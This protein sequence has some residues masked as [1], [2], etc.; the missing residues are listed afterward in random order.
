MAMLFERCDDADHGYPLRHSGANGVEDLLGDAFLG[1]QT[2]YEEV[3]A[4]LGVEV[5][6]GL[7]GDKFVPESR[8][9]INIERMSVDVHPICG[10]CQRARVHV[11]AERCV[12]ATEDEIDEG[13]DAHA[14]ASK[15]D[16]NVHSVAL[17]ERNKIR[18][19]T[20]GSVRERTHIIHR[21]GHR[22]GS[23]FKRV[24]PAQ[25]TQHGGFAEELA[26]YEEISR[27]HPREAGVWGT[28]AVVG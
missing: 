13:A 12:L 4:P 23:S 27:R 16:N 11:G 22:L 21:Q 28:H 2:V 8:D 7:F 3:Y 17:L 15:D 6:D 14:S 19:F 25:P 5:A 1:S 24:Q 10:W 9:V 20:R 18:L 26:W